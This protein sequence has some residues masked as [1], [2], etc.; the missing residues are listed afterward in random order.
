MRLFGR[1]AKNFN[2]SKA[3]VI[4]TMPLP[5][6]SA[7]RQ[8]P[9][10]HSGGISG[11][12]VVSVGDDAP[13]VVV[14]VAVGGVV[15]VV[16]AVVVVVVV[17]EDVEDDVPL[18]VV[19]VAVSGVVTV[20]VIARQFA[21]TPLITPLVKKYSQRL[22]RIALPVVVVAV[23]VEVIVGGVVTDVTLVVMLVVVGG[24]VAVVAVVCV[25]GLLPQFAQPSSLHRISVPIRTQRLFTLALPELR[26][27]PP[28]PSTVNETSY[29]VAFAVLN[30][31]TR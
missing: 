19:T 22:Q 5:S 21:Q 18:V 7:I 24:V 16:V 4:F 15:T 23:F 3:S 13:L 20:V 6:T 27:R 8:S 9:L 17:A 12:V 26:F 31:G 28:K 10:Q 30:C 1:F 11:V 14:T 2:I 25:V 29:K